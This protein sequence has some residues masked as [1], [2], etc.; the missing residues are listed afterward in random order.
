MTYDNWHLGGISFNTFLEL[1][2]D[3]PELSI[4]RVAS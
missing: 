2:G 3:R 1:F 4:R